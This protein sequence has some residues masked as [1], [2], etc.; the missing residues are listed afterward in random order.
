MELSLKS[1]PDRTGSSGTSVSFPLRT[2]F[3]TG[4]TRQGAVILRRGHGPSPFCRLPSVPQREPRT[5][6]FP[7]FTE[8]FLSSP[9][10]W[11]S[12]VFRRWIEG[13]REH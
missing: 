8:R 4:S 13:E 2:D 1:D 11:L 9:V 5:K 3:G 6:Q 7:Y 12:D 10:S